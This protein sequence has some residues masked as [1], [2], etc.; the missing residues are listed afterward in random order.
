MGVGVP[1]AYSPCEQ[2]TTTVPLRRTR[3]ARLGIGLSCLTGERRYGARGGFKSGRGLLRRAEQPDP[4][5]VY[6]F[7]DQKQA[8]FP[9][10][11]MCRV[12]EVS[13]AGYYAWRS[14][15]L[16]RRR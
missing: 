15:P 8:A 13:Y 10:R 6:E 12:L 2:V 9:I 16:C 4:V 5:S 11:L 3:P 7:I 1:D 14:R